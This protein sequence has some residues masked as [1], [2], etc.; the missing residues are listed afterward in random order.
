MHIHYINSDKT[1]MYD[2]GTYKEIIKKNLFTCCP[3]RHFYKKNFYS[4]AVL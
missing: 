2:H 3:L 4:L 1:K